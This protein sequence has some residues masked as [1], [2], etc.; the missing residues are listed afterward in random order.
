MDINWSEILTGV[1]V[2]LLPPL[3]A[4]FVRWLWAKGSELFAQIAKYDEGLAGFLRE[5]S[6]FAIRAAEQAG[7]GEVINDKKEYALEIAEKY[8]KE[9]FGVSPDLDLISA[10]IEKAV[11]EEF[12]SPAAI[13][14]E[15]ENERQY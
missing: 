9:R 14:R 11:W 10:A 2:V 12:N 5:A 1:L 13:E 7:L 4:A 8:L 3:I 15:R 6:Y